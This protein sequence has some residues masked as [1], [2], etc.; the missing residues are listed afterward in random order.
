MHAS[1]NRMTGTTQGEDKTGALFDQEQW[2]ADEKQ[3]K[4]RIIAFSDE[5]TNQARVSQLIEWAFE[6]GYGRDAS[7][8]L[9]TFDV[10]SI[11][12]HEKPHVENSNCVMLLGSAVP[13]S[14]DPVQGFF[15]WGLHAGRV[16]GTFANSELPNG[17]KQRA[18]RPVHILQ[19]GT[20]L[21][22]DK[23]T[24][25]IGRCVSGVHEYEPIRHGGFAPC[26]PCKLNDE[27]MRLVEGT[28]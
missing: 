18:K 25:W 28:A 5:D 17:S 22:T 16:G 9:G 13:S 20:I 14:K 1:I 10:V 3:N 21:K 24:D 19:R 26:L 12:P 27:T 2:Y 11:T 15:S 23:P 6:G 4:F 7:S 8:G